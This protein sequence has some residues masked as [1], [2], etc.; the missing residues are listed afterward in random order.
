MGLLSYTSIIKKSITEE[1]KY[2]AKEED[3]IKTSWESCNR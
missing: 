1:H 3:F 2:D